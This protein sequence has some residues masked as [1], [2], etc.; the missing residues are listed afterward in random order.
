MLAS[1]PITRVHLEE[2]TARSIHAGGKSL[3]DFNRAGIPLM[4]LVTDP[5][6]RDAETAGNFA[7]ELQLLLRTLGASNANL[8]KGEMRI[9][10]NISVS[11]DE[12]KFGTKVE[13][14]NLN[15]FRSVERAIAF[16][17][18][19]QVELLTKG[20]QVT[21]ETRGWDEAKEV[22][23]S[24]RIKEGS[25][26]Y[27]YFPE[28]DLPKLILS[29]VPE[30]TEAAIKESLPELPWERR[31]RY[32]AL[33]L[34]S[35]TV[36]YIGS[37]ISRSSFFDSV[38]SLLENDQRLTALAANYF[39]TDVA[40]WYAK[41][42][43]E[44][45]SLAPSALASL[46]RMIAEDKVS[47]R[48]AKDVLAMLLEKGGDPETIAREAG[49]EQVS[50]A[51]TL[52]VAVQEVI[53]ANES[54]VAEYRAGKQTALQYLVGQGMKATRGAGNPA[55]LRDLILKEIQSPD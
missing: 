52:R 25:A 49:L 12:G 2:D 9:E 55:L 26:D 4:E 13:V 27:R 48:G 24:Q 33:G 38:L 21:Q 43:T 6:I 28:P 19:R 54:V 8:E 30:F 15:S 45:F 53:R 31:I 3:V 23:F 1:I 5:A 51:A 39:S 22:T 42:E 41:H 7:R 20:G 32:G 10:A 50:D 46:V 29:E 17:I 14:K 16:E 34:S 37:D 44:A 11:P 47:S 40:G 18:L 36:A 35:D